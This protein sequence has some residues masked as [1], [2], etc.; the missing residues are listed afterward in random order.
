MN[1]PPIV[2]VGKKY[3][4]V[5]HGDVF[6]D[7]PLREGGCHRILNPT[8]TLFS[9]GP[10]QNLIYEWVTGAQPQLSVPGFDPQH[11]NTSVN[12]AQWEIN[13]QC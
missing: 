11:P 2:L 8:D 7:T 1:K 10:R 9:A 6:W 3:N 13:A 4:T 12:K 5:S